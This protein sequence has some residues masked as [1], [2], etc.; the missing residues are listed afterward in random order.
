M[1][2]DAHIFYLA[3][4]AFALGIL[5]ESFWSVGLSGIALFVLV[6]V[7][8]VV[9]GRGRAEGPPAPGLVFTALILFAFSLGLLR[10]DLAESRATD[11]Y[12]ES[13]VETSVTIEGVIK[14]EPEDRET[15]TH[16]YVKTDHGLILVTTE[17]GGDWRYG[18]RVS[19][20]GKLTKPE[21]FETDLGRTFNYPGY[22]LARGVAYTA[23]YARAERLGEGE[24]NFLITRV[25]VLKQRFMKEVERLLPEPAAGLG[26]GLLLGVKRALGEELE[27]MFRRTGIIHIV[28][29]SGYN[30]M[31]VV[32]FI[33]FVLGSLFG[34]KLSTTFGIVGIVLFAIM[35]GL[36]ATVVRAS[37]MASL[38][39]LLGLTGRVY[40]VLRGLILA[41]VIMLVYNPYSLAFDVGFQLSFLATLG[42][43]LVSPYLDERLQA[44]PNKWISA[45][46]FLVA[47]L[48][49]QIFVLPILLYQIG[50]F[51][52]V[53]VI[54][55]VL[56]L[57]MV[58]VAMLLTFLT[59]IAGLLVGSLATPL[60]Y[61]TYLSLMYIIKMAEWFGSLPFAA[62]V[63]PPFPF[64]MV[65][66]GY[67]VI[68]LIL[69]HL[70]REPDPLKG[71]TIKEDPS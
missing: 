58:A 68:G 11:P 5:A 56:V 51:S 1:P 9:A 39:L 15:S 21:S 6:G 4:I 28:V 53:A 44:V 50:E 71:W 62:F 23:R 64:Y 32:A 47:T 49:T 40:L 34:R 36:G 3:G 48:A 8:V 2:N 46:E 27:T 29:L 24:G 45:R 57:P 26:E 20:T 18:D 35:V 55:N 67:A 10:M 61:V 22:L 37:I 17:A 19:F 33:L 63:V 30:V 31:M 14:R 65:P 59:G 70:N 7:A 16:L 38:L 41:G 52:V 54:V 13:L 43:I 60:A 66:L 12:L 69:W 42:L 25:F